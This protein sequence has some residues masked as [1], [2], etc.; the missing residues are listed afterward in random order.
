[1]RIAWTLL[2]G[3]AVVSAIEP[4]NEMTGYGK[5]LLFHDPVV[6]ENTADFEIFQLRATIQLI[7]NTASLA[8]QESEIENE[9]N[10]LF[11]EDKLNIEDAQNCTLVKTGD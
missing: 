5:F 2:M 8:D 6:G 3:A 10:T 9:I 11:C 7:E 1:M 4:V